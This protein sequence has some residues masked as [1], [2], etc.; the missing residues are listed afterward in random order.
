MV[1]C[2][3]ALEQGLA[4]RAPLSAP[5]CRV[6]SDG[7]TRSQ[8]RLSQQWPWRREWTR[9]SPTISFLTSTSGQERIDGNLCDL[10]FLP[11]Q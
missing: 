10:W 7:E 8:P 11:A 4:Y 2:G 9:I 3:A 1:G 6:V 5:G